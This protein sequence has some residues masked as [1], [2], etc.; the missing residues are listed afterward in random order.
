[1]QAS[2]FVAVLEAEIADLKARIDAAEQ[3]WARRRSR[4]RIAA[5]VPERLVRLH[6]EL[7]EATRLVESLKKRRTRAAA[8]SAPRPEPAS[9]Q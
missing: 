2:L 6:T 4:S 7:A 9:S 1:V 8:S 3:R 5:E